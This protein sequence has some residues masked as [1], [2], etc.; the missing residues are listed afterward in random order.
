[1]SVK[2]PLA[3]LIRMAGIN[4]DEDGSLWHVNGRMEREPVPTRDDGR[5]YL[6]CD[7]RIGN[8]RRTAKVHR[9]VWT[10]WRGE[11]PDGMHVDHID[12]DRHNNAVSNLRLRDPSEN[13]G[14]CRK[15]TRK[16]IAKT[17]PLQRKAVQSLS[18]CCFQT[19]EVAALLGLGASTVRRIKKQN[20]RIC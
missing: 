19:A 5:G 8:M 7:F 9:L 16:G 20:P 18:E 15:T 12:H 2:L 13:S 17:T 4:F 6:C 11:I 14:D 1:M 3:S 10:Y